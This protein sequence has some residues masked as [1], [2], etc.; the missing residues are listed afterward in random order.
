MIK[1]NEPALSTSCEL[2]LSSLGDL[3]IMQN[4]YIIYFLNYI[5]TRDDSVVVS[6]VSMTNKR[7]TFHNV[8]KMWVHFFL[9]LVNH[10]D[11][12]IHLKHLNT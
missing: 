8:T 10:I 1:R 6:S 7:S 4:M 9:W 3:K 5:T 12:R 11:K 2:G